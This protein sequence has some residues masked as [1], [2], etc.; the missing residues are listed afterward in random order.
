[1]VP[2]TS[3]NVSIYNHSGSVDV[4]ADVFGYYTDGGGN[5]TPV[6]PTRLLDTRNGTGAPVAKVQPNQT[7]NLHVANLAGVPSNASSVILNVTVTNPT[8]AGF[9]S[10]Y[11]GG[12]AFLPSASNL[13]FTKGETIP[14]LVV[15]PVTNGSVNIYNR[16]GTVD[17]IA[18]VFGYYTG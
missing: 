8:A 1:M 2:I 10:V 15:V 7:L 17:V 13:N 3:G 16:S 14:N 18:D 4:I 6:S 5:F 11:P 9:L 12:Q